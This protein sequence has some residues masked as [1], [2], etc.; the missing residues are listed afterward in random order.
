VSY[1]FNYS[2]R[3]W[4]AEERLTLMCFYGIVVITDTWLNHYN[5]GIQKGAVRADGNVLIFVSWKLKVER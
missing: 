2:K 5:I 3:V 4:L 1:I